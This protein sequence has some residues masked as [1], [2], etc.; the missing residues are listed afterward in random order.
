MLKNSD[1]FD[2]LPE[3]YHD[4]AFLDRIHCY[5]P[6]WEF[7]QIRGEMFSN[8]YGFVVDYLAEVLKSMRD[9]DYS[10]RYQG[11]FALS[12]SI[13]TRDR[14]GIHKTF[15]G[16]MQLVHPT[17]EA[18]PEEMEAVLCAA[19]E[20]RKRVKDQLVRIDTTMTQVRF[21]YEGVDREWRSVA[22]L[23]E[24]EYPELYYRDAEETEPHGE[25]PEGILSRVSEQTGEMPHA[26]IVAP[27]P[28]TVQ[29]TTEPT[30][31]KLELKEQHFSLREGQRNFS[32]DRFFGPYLRGATQIT[33]KD[34]FIRMPHQMRNL[35]ELIETIAKVADSGTEVKVHL[36]TKPDETAEQARKQLESLKTIRTSALIAGIDFDYEF[37]ETL[38][39]RSIQADTGWLLILGRGLDV[40]Q[41][42]DTSWFDLR[43]RQQR[44]RQVKEFEIT[45]VCQPDAEV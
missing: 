8:G 32:Y 34:P 40:F 2:E 4:P 26:P 6:G 10:D 16:L 18:S 23:E 39:D 31:L 12:D 45:Y 37:S 21:G 28:P 29:E 9:I 36:V 3:Q 25:E 1:L 19:I 11:S 43:L 17:G 30:S 42:F 14:D 15:S 20:G 27:A 38:H 13:S 22:T 33:I 44:Y 35:M 41:Q 7:E 24:N 5:I